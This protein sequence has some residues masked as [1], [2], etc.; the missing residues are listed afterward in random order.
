M[1]KSIVLITFII[2]LLLF[3][4][5]G[6][7]AF[8]QEKAVCTVD[9]RYFV[10]IQSAIDYIFA[11]SRELSDS[12]KTITVTQDIVNSKVLDSQRGSVS[13]PEDLKG[14]LIIDLNGHTYEFAGSSFF[15][16]NGTAAEILNGTVIVPSDNQSSSS[17][18]RI[19][20]GVLTLKGVSLQDRR[21]NS[22][23]VSLDAG[24]KM[25]ITSSDKSKSSVSGSF[26]IAE[27]A[28]LEIKD[29]IINFTEL[30]EPENSTA[31]IFIYS[32]TITN[33]HDLNDRITAA[34]S[35]VRPSD[36]G[37]IIRSI[38]HSPV[39]YVPQIAPTCFTPGNIQYFVCEAS[40]CG[41]YFTDKECHHEITDKTSV[42]LDIMPHQIIENS[43]VS[44]SC[45]A[46]GNTEYYKCNLCETFFS[47]REGNSIIENK[48]SVFI[49]ALGHSISFHKE[50]SSD[51]VTH[52]HPSYYQCSTC[53]KY[54][55]DITGSKEVL[56]PAELPL[57]NHSWTS[58]AYTEAEHWIICTICGIEKPDTKEKH[59]FE[60][61]WNKSDK[62][63]LYER[64]CNTCPQKEYTSVCIWHE[65][66]AKNPTCTEAGNKEYAYCEVHR[67]YYSFDKS[68]KLEWSAIEIPALGHTE[69]KN[70][71]RSNSDSHWKICETCENIIDEEVHTKEWSYDATN[72]WWKC[73]DCHYETVLVPHTYSS[74]TVSEGIA[75]K[76]CIE[77]N[78]KQEIT[79]KGHDLIYVEAEPADCTHDGRKAYYTCDGLDEG[80]VFNEDK[81]AVI[82]FDSTYESIKEHSLEKID[83]RRP[84]CNAEGN[85]EYYSCNICNK[86]FKDIT[87]D[88]EIT[89][90][91][92]M[93]A[94][95]DHV[96]NNEK[97]TCDDDSH[98]SACIYGCGEYRLKNFHTW[99]WEIISIGIAEKE[100]S[101]CHHTL[102]TEGK[103]VLIP[104]KVPTPYE[105]GNIEYYYCEAYDL[106][107]SSTEPKI[108]YQENTVVKYQ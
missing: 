16:F 61:N 95:T 102:T 49:P 37:E 43:A 15:T 107:L 35:A 74:W 2:I 12:A 77:S 17:A 20:N 92:A 38:V 21:N 73:T 93:L 34:I 64:E 56:P 58:I 70:G 53:R 57:A 14:K 51:C 94:K 9:S 65:Y 108:I 7:N 66:A 106:Y 46:S 85:I 6:E 90:K 91:E 55:S 103:T 104:A 47:D 71:F 63:G 19:T 60:G 11:S 86:L 29:S 52:G 45:T 27:D 28:R 78:C 87:A 18:F 68:N 76:K 30:K 101:V 48:N 1:K 105:D 82:S 81:T 31:N 88:K 3:S 24:S 33:T 40:G 44:P 84:A 69:D 97:W 5:N 32:G 36:R 26:N 54:Y 23:A 100:C 98:W 79:T 41:K 8:R 10:S 67:E 96:F 25:T 72:H 75:T 59:H 99:N 22:N 4:C 83:A 80:M 42:V 50:I 13:V 89:L 62:E 39:K